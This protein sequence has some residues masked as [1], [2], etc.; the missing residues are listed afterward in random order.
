MAKNIVHLGEKGYGSD[1]LIRARKD[2][3]CEWCKK[4]IHKGELYARHS[5][6][7]FKEPL[8]PVCGDCAWWLK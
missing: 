4:D 6:N 8:Y 2:Y 3:T 5:P 1:H 7:K